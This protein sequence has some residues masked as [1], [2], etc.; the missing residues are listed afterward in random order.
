MVPPPFGGN[1]GRGQ[2]SNNYQG[3]F[4][5]SRTSAIPSIKM[6][7][8]VGN[9]A[10]CVDLLPGHPYLVPITPTGA[11]AFSNEITASAIAF[12]SGQTIRLNFDYSATPRLLLHWGIGWKEGDFG[13]QSPFLGYDAQTQLGLKGELLPLYFPRISAMSHR[14]G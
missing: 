11:D 4:D 3:T 14:P 7:Q 10:P 8:N 9:Q 1:A 12:N 13:L 5:S 2:A 6:D